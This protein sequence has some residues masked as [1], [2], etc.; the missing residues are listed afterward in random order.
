M[1]AGTGPT[2]LSAGEPRLVPSTDGTSVA[3]RSTLLS[4]AAAVVGLLSYG[5]AL[6]M[7]HILDA[8]G[9]SQF[10]G[11]QML[12]G[13][14]GVLGAAL[15]QLP[16]VHIVR[17]NPPSS[18]A[19][20]RGMAFAWSVSAAVGIAAAAAT[21]SVT[22][23]FAPAE[24]AVAVAASAF[25]MV[26]VTP[27]WGWLLGELRFLR[28]AVTTVAEV[29]V[30]IVCSVTAAVIG[31]GAGGALAGFAAGSVSVLLLTPLALRRDV[32]W[33]PSVLTERDRWTD[34]ADIALVQVI[35]AVVVGV[36]VVLVALLGAGTEAVAGYQALSTLAKGPVY[37]AAGAAS[38]AFPLLR[39]P[40]ARVRD[41]LTA[42]LRSFGLLA[43]PAAA[44]LATVPERVMLLVLPQRYAPSLTMLP[45]LA[46]S[47]VGYAAV[48]ALATILLGLRAY[49]R[50]Q[51]GLLLTVVLLPTGMI[52]GWR[53]D[54]VHGLAVGAAAGAG[55]AAIVMWT[56]A[57]S[58]LPPRM[59]GRAARALVAAAGWAAVL[60]LVRGHVV[61][62]LA[63]A[64]LS[65]AFVLHRLRAPRAHRIGA[66]LR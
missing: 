34:T 55:L 24:V 66:D 33:C 4:A 21:A 35:L 64:A 13:M 46:A 11:G 49:R 10:A 16:L 47:G 63:L 29:V 51:L 61:V 40:D 62:W 44:V 19:R 23:L 43:L 37:V 25:A 58:L 57:N 17:S 30:R 52:L 1:R 22:A 31:W 53:F 36:D 56:F 3:S 38:V 27:I 48:T 59:N 8:R 54:T 9:Y 20:R 32:T 7:T 42:T 28:F 60:D 15:T 26:L 12:L 45:I 18:V 39:S 50:S 6:T 14:V 41:I 65:G 2:G 5:C